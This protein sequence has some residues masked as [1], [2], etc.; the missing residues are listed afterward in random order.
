MYCENLIDFLK[1]IKIE[2]DELHQFN[3]R[4][5]QYHFNDDVIEN[6]RMMRD[7]YYSS[8]GFSKKN[9]QKEYIENLEIA[10]WLLGIYDIAFAHNHKDANPRFHK[11]RYFY[12]GLSKSEYKLVSGIYRSNEKEENFYFRELLVRCPEKLSN[13]KNFNKLTYMQHYGSPTRLLDITSNPLVALYFACEK[14]KKQDGIVYVL[15]VNPDE[16]AYETSDRVQMLSHLQELSGKDQHQLL[17]LSYINLLK[18]K[19][20]QTT[21]S[22]YKDIELERFFYSIQKENAVFQ[23]EIIP[24]DLLRPVF[25]QANQNN[26]RILKQDGAFIMSGLDIDERDS[27]KKICKH[28]VKEITIPY[29]AKDGIL[30]DLELVGIH[31]ASLFPELETVSEYLKEKLT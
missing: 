10:E 21:N 23:R 13:L 22:K 24:L 25:V 11:H 28:V 8:D 30:K 1:K 18:D 5:N 15:G 20:P 3:K 7:N 17:M 9:F 31:K 4:I 6:M 27:H 14:N 29:F 2:N 16:I 19:F 26:R 12:R